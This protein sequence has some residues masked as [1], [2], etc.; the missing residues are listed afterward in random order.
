M[1]SRGSNAKVLPAELLGLSEAE[2]R[3]L[4]VQRMRVECAFH[5][6][7]G[8]A[9][10]VLRSLRCLSAG[11]ACAAFARRCSSPSHTLPPS[12][13][14]AV[15]HKCDQ[16][17]VKAK[18][19]EKSIRSAF[20]AE[21]FKLGTKTCAMVWDDFVAQH[22]AAAAAAAGPST[23]TL[24]GGKHAAGGEKR[25]RRAPRPSTIFHVGGAVASDAEAVEIA[26]TGEMTEEALKQFFQQ[27]MQ[28][29]QRQ[30]MAAGAGGRKGPQRR[31]R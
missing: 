25:K 29:L 12:P 10:C 5:L 30:K 28:L 13:S 24:R 7:D 9:R 26:V 20:D 16:L 3:A 31:R 14:F 4:H 15:E 6:L 27:Q 17:A 21:E 22:E 11:R 1:S 8:S 2:Q 19:I 18:K 23:T